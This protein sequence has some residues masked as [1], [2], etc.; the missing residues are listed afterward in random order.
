MSNNISVPTIEEIYDMDLDTL[1]LHNKNLLLLKDKLKLNDEISNERIINEDDSLDISY[2]SKLLSFIKYEINERKSSNEL[3]D[4]F[5]YM[6]VEKLISKIEEKI[7]KESKENTEKEN[8]Q[9]YDINR[10]M[11][12][13]NMPLKEIKKI[14]NLNKYKGGSLNMN[15]KENNK[16]DNKYKSDNNFYKSPCFI[17]SNSKKRSENF[18]KEV[19]N[20]INHIKQVSLNTR[21]KSTMISKNYKN[22]ITEIKCNINNRNNKIENEYSNKTFALFNK[23][24]ITG[25]QIPI[26]VER[27]KSVMINKK[28]NLKKK[29]KIKSNIVNNQLTNYELRKKYSD[30]ILNTVSNDLPKINIKIENQKQSEIKNNDN[31]IEKESSMVK[32]N[33]QNGK[34]N[35]ININNN[36]VEDYYEE[37]ENENEVKNE[38]IDKIIVDCYENDNF[39]KTDNN[40]DNS[41]LNINGN[42]NISNIV[43]HKKHDHDDKITVD[44]QIHEDFLEFNIK[45]PLKNKTHKDSNDNLI[46]FRL[47]TYS[48]SELNK[49]KELKQFIVFSSYSNN[50]NKEKEIEKSQLESSP[51]L[52]NK[53]NVVYK[54]IQNSK[55]NIK[56]NKNEITVINHNQ[57]KYLYKK[58][59]IQSK[60]IIYKKT[61]NTWKKNNQILKL[62]QKSSIL[63]NPST[64][65][66]DYSKHFPTFFHLFN[67]YYLSKSNANKGHLNGK[68]FDYIGIMRD[69][70]ISFKNLIEYEKSNIKLKLDGHVKNIV[71]YEGVI[72]NNRLK[73]L[74]NSILYNQF[75]D[76]SYEKIYMH[77]KIIDLQK[78]MTFNDNS[79]SNINNFDDNYYN[80]DQ[81]FYRVIYN[82]PEIYD[83][84]NYCFGIKSTWRELPHGLQLGN[85]WNILWTYSYPKINYSSILSIQK[86]NHYINN[87]I[88]ARKDLLNK[89]INRIRAINE[90][91]NAEFNIIPQTFLLGKEY[92]EFLDAYMK[93]GGKENKKN[94]WIV[95]PN[96]SSRGKGIFLTNEL[97]EVSPI[98]GYI[99]QKYILNPLLIDGLYKFDMRIYALVTSVNPLEAF[100]YN[101]GFARISN[102][103]YTLQ[104]LD[105]KIHL[106]NAAIQDNSIQQKLNKRE[107]Q[108]K[109]A[110]T[111]Q[112]KYGGSKISLDMLKRKLSK[113][114]ISW[115]LI[116][117]QVKIIVLK[118]LI[119]AQ[120]DIQFSPSCFEL[121][122]FDVLIDSNLNCFLIEVNMSPSLERSNVLDDQIKLQ[123]IDD[124]IKLLDVPK[125]NKEGIIEVLERRIKQETMNS[126]T[127]SINNNIYSP[128]AQ[129]NIDMNRIFNGQLPRRYGENPKEMGKFEKIAP[130][131][132][133][134]RLIKI[135]HSEKD[136]FNLKKEWKLRETINY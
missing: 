54:E 66:I 45:S 80:K 16:N 130:T 95:K 133:S 79:N 23:N 90:K 40:I 28:S 93:N 76:Q 110:T 20:T 25:N 100:I 119:S 21:P 88:I 5:K 33:I 57:N 114:H 11:N 113:S 98:D 136:K 74:S 48:S 46:T 59:L 68:G 134:E 15:N 14:M 39:E 53:E 58:P 61:I 117:E 73:E 128:I 75:D 124:I 72:I 13:N 7:I 30:T 34:E 81:L 135:S 94:I 112:Q 103:P 10:E 31:S 55:E 67:G 85:T 120:L 63:Q 102:F 115:N 97:S 60:E 104:N 92:L 50:E 6:T 49:D 84:V 64:Q 56:N 69:L 41:N 121:F 62:K 82:R 37:I 122:G 111:F 26:I 107:R 27:P 51:V 3:I 42:E 8:R 123:L 126:T 125:I 129:L 12:I 101:E 118:T 89:S 105:I 77:R 47:N 99:V 131:Y 17:L 65:L 106:T 71:K 36:I 132:D 4:Y 96:A 32:E 19:I 70:L 86:V 22:I 18:N 127:L 109:S 38:N 43:L 78:I 9:S 83:I 44:N 2:L 87:R 29:L 91:S 24:E 52:N 35:V 108:V 1:E 116:W